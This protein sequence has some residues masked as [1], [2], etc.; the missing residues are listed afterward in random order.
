MNHFRGTVWRHVP[1]G[2][3]PLHVGRILHALGRWNRSGI[4]GCLYTALTIE[5]ARAEYEK[6]FGAVG[7]APETRARRDLVSIEIDVGPVL[8]LTDPVVAAQ[9]NVTQEMLCADSDDA[10]ELCRTIATWARIQGYRAILA[11]SAAAAGEVNLMVYVDGT[12]EHLHLEVGSD[13]MPLV[14]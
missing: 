8:D 7:S 14:P 1:A 9:L 2:A 11:P 13:R 12:A 3:N 6:H 4:F 10:L 5:G